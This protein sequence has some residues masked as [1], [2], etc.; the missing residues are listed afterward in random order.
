MICGLAVAQVHNDQILSDCVV[1]VEG[2]FGTANSVVSGQGNPALNEAS[3]E[4][5][6]MLEPDEMHSIGRRI[7]NATKIDDLHGCDEIS[8]YSKLIRLCS[9]YRFHELVTQEVVSVLTTSCMGRD[10]SRDMRT[11]Q[12]WGRNS[13]GCGIGG[14]SVSFVVPDGDLK[15]DPDP[16]FVAEAG[17]RVSRNPGV[18]R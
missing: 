12:R 1:T 8:R 4:A 17:S 9:I 18:R 3:S 15:A 7:D 13:S 14:G 10:S 5:D 16:V 6:S 11:P 2:I